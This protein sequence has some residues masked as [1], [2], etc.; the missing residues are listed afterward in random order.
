MLRKDN[1]MSLFTEKKKFMCSIVTTTWELDIS[2]KHVREHE[3]DCNALS[4]SKKLVAFYAKSVQSR[5]K[6]SN[7]LSCTTSAR[8]DV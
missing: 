7:I 1:G 3:Q 6:V 2:K 4:V 5:V 8:I